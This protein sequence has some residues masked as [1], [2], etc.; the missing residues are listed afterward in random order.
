MYNT[1]SIPSLLHG[2]KYESKA[3]DMYF[4]SHEKKHKMLNCYTT[5]LVIDTE[6]PFL[7]ASPDDFVECDCCENVALK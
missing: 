7:G 5:G 4:K 6:L 3:R 1:C 2:R